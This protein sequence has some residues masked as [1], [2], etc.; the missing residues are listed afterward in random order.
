MIFMDAI[1]AGDL[2]RNGNNKFLLNYRVI[3]LICSMHYR[4]AL[5]LSLTLNC[6]N[7]FVFLF[8]Y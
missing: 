3:S 5:T 6:V 4:I 7:Q 2:Y 8:V 1:H